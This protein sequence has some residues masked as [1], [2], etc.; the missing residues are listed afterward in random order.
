MLASFKQK[1]LLRIN[2]LVLMVAIL[3]NVAP[4]VPGSVATVVAADRAAA[5]L[6]TVAADSA[7][8]TAPF[9]E[10][11]DI[12][13]DDSAPDA[14]QPI[15]QATVA[16]AADPLASNSLALYLPSITTESY[17]FVHEIPD[18]GGLNDEN[19]SAASGTS[20]YV[21]CNNGRDGNSGLGKAAAW[22]S[23]TK[24]NTAPLRPGDKLLFKR[25]CT[26]RGPLRADWNGTAT[27]PITIAA[28]GTGNLPK[29]QN[30]YNVNV[31][32]SGSHQIIKYLEATQSGAVNPDPNCNNQS[33]GWKVGFSFAGNAA[34]NTLSNSRASNNA[35][36][37]RT[38]Y[39]AHHNR[40]INNNIV[41][42]TMVWELRPTATL[43]AMGVLLHGDHNEVGHNYFRNNMSICTYTGTAESNSVELYGARFSNIHHNTA[44]NDRVFS[45]IGGETGHPSADNTFAYNL[46]VVTLSDPTGARFIVTRG[47][48]HVNGPVYRTNVYNNTIYFSGS[49]AKGISCALCATN[50]LI[51]KNNVLWVNREPISVDGGFVEERNLFWS[52]DGRPLIN[53][54]RSSSSIVANPQFRDT[55]RRDFRVRSGSEA[56]DNASMVT[57]NLGHRR[58]LGGTNIWQGSAPDLGSYEYR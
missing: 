54:T 38:D 36:G 10:P 17:F 13:A 32:I 52:S 11:D 28:Y 57:F 15:E 25:G 6:Q 19:I 24:A 42:N 18:D 44:I 55:S 2:I 8:V 51:V 35:M 12:F 26:W 46:H 1:P 56:I 3:V 50:I 22:R 31:Q 45:E 4:L 37:V 5:N 7:Q 23:I 27:Q 30:S 43:G 21:D 53:F 58:D 40:I 49:N 29:I 9:W 47:V 16:A 39:D 34:Y 33:V 20:Y 48:G 14:G 41:N